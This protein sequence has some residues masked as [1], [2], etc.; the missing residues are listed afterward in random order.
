MKRIQLLCIAL[1]SI[2]ILSCN[3]YRKITF[4]NVDFYKKDRVAKNID[5]YDVILHKKDS[6]YLLKNARLENKTLSGE[7]EVVASMSNSL[8]KSINDEG[9][10]DI[11]IYLENNNTTN[12]IETGKAIELKESNV[13]KA[14][15]YAKDDDG[16]AGVAMTVL[17]IVLVLIVALI[18]V[19]LLALNSAANT[20]GSGS[21]SSGSDSGG[22]SCYVATMAYG[23][24]DAEQVVLLRQ[25]RDRFLVK[26]ALGRKF[27][28]WYYTKS[29]SFVEQHKSKIWLHKTIRVLLNGLVEFLRLFLKK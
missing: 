6:T 19:L 23:S 22:S 12:G 1:I 2:F 16:I 21:N 17:I 13:E 10:N 26:F 27:I 15:M 29:P 4:S 25:F 18:I 28:S 3:P 8:V 5:R 11:H 9:K 24:Q 14:E 20:I 7:V